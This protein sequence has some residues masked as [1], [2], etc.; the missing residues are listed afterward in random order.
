M[1]FLVNFCCSSFLRKRS[2]KAPRIFHDEFHAT[3]H[4]TF[5][6]CKCSI[7]WHFSL[8]RRLFLRSLSPCRRL[9]HRL[10]EAASRLTTANSQTL[11]HKRRSPCPQNG[12]HPQTP[13]GVWA[14]LGL[15][16]EPL[17]LRPRI[18]VKKSVVLVKRENGFTKT[19][20]SLFFQGFLSRGRF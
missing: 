11:A 19:L 6:S 10:S 17:P 4:E 5:C 2:S 12:R 8:C 9:D 7:S 16:Q 20:L 1:K 18:F 13:L 14:Q 15:I 3:F